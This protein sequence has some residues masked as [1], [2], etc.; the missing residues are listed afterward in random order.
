MLYSSNRMLSFV[1]G[2]LKRGQPNHNLLQATSNG[3]GRYIGKAR[4]L[5]KWP[6]VVSSRYNIPYILDC[7]GKGN[8]VTGE[9]YEI[10]D[11]MLAALDKLEA[12][13]VY[14]QRTDIQVMMY[15]D[16]DGRPLQSQ[17]PINCMFYVLRNYKDHLLNLEFLEEYKDSEPLKY[18]THGERTDVE[19]HR[20]DVMHI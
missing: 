7:A 15:E 18:C 4:T 16:A 8:N 2:T 5:E 9:V 17:S 14:Y 19:D 3:K 20:G 6:L 12:H 11:K 10:D 1:Y 13:P